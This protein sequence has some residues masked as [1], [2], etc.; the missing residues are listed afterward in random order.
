VAEE[1]TGMEGTEAPATAG[2]L[3]HEVTA[4]GGDGSKAQWATRVRIDIAGSGFLWNMVRIIAG[5]LVD[6]GRGRIPPDDIP[7]IIESKDRR[8]AGPTLPPTGLCLEWI[9]YE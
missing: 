6:V 4:G 8:R 1:G 3:R 7:A 2:R 9:K 5:T